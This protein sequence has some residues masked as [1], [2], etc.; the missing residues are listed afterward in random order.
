MHQSLV[1]DAP[2]LRHRRWNV[3]A[4][5]DDVADNPARVR[6]QR[7]RRV[8]AVDTTTNVIDTPFVEQKVAERSAA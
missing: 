3:G 4:T 7:L 5:F 1:N 8:C 6:N 2:G